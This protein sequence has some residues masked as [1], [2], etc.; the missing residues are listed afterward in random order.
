MSFSVEAFLLFIAKQII[1]Q[2][3]CVHLYID[4]YS[5]AITCNTAIP[6]NI[7]ANRT[8]ASRH[9]IGIKILLIS[10]TASPSSYTKAA[11]SD[12]PHQRQAAASYN[13]PDAP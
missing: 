10:F 8:A 3:S 5:Y 7:C 6:E 9:Q 4:G 1:L 12:K 11:Y 2:L 13:S